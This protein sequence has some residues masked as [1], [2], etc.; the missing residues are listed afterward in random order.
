VPAPDSLAQRVQ[1]LERCLEAVNKDLASRN[2][3]NERLHSRNEELER[4]NQ[5]LRRKLDHLVRH[6]FGGTKN[7]G[8]SNAQLELALLGLPTVLEALTQPPKT[9]SEISSRPRQPRRG[10]EGL[11]LESRETV[12]EP[13][14]VQADPQGWTKL[15][16][17]RTTQLDFEPGKF[18]RHVIIRPRYVRREE[19]AI[20]PLPAQPIDKGA[21]GAG[22]L[23]WLLMGKF[24]DHLPLYRQGEIFE[25]QYGV[26]IPRST[27]IDWVEQAAELVRPIYRV[28]RE[29]LL[30]H[31][32]LQVDETAIRYLDPEIRGASRKGWMWVY[33]RPGGDVLFEWNLGRSRDGPKEFLGDFQGQLQTDGLGVYESLV[34]EM[35]GVSLVY[36]W[37]HARRG[38]HEGL[39]E[40]SRLAAWFL[41]QI[42]QLYS[43]EAQLRTLKAGP[44]LRGAYR[45]SRSAPVLRRLHQAMLK[46]RTKL[47]PSGALAEAINYTLKRWEGLNHFVRNP[48]LEIDNNLV[49]NAI[50]PSALGKKNWLFIGH[51]KA[52][53]RA[54]IFYSL[55]GSC[56]RRRINP[57]DYL[58]DVL[59]RLPG[60]TNHQVADFTPAAWA[61]ARKA[62]FAPTHSR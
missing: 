9:R 60:A 11:N 13:S 18:F 23:A 21:V 4:E 34:R 62:T 1:N 25:R 49:E 6:Y 61:K 2:Q 43:I 41:G 44:A 36:C 26:K 55:I 8:L 24:A 22:L 31:D 46:I 10:I 19:F 17:E 50:R 59:Q 5:L 3:E 32:Y 35:P 15:S 51:P 29:E 30:Q 42:G 7:E 57:Y 12:L 37:A 38:F 39:A 27:L 45:I 58:R 33:S 54:A 47:L 28:M 48:R 20:A 53:D 16:E 40:Q 56:R 52:G 14:Q